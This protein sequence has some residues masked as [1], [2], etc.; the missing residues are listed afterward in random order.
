[1]KELLA[2]TLHMSPKTIGKISVYK[3]SFCYSN[4]PTTGTKEL[5]VST[6]NR[7]LVGT[8]IS[9]GDVSDI[10]AIQRYLMHAENFA[11][12]KNSFIVHPH[13]ESVI[14]EAVR[15]SKEY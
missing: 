7:P 10:F 15:L 5:F 13:V 9:I 14:M 4:V 11:R 12:P 6:A 3:H 2:I 1:M 8:L